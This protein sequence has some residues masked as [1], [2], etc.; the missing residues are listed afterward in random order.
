[1]SS[2]RDRNSQ[3]K[4][5]SKKGK[6]W[7]EL[8]QTIVTAGIVS[9]GIRTFAA[10]PRFIPSGSMQPTLQIDDRLIIDKVSYHFQTPKR[11]D[12]VVFSPTKI[13]QIEH[14][15]D[16][17]IKR[18]IGIPGDKIEVKQGKVY[19]NDRALVENY[20]KEIPQYQYG[21]IVVPDDRYLVLGD[22]RN[23]SY[24]S[25]Y[26]GFVPRQNFIGKA[27]VRYWPLDRIDLLD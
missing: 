23:N 19:R 1:M 18:V 25:H 17:F 9:L 2:D 14:F 20:I 24:D 27:S 16:D 4:T 12:I 21:P 13:L 8:V 3:A 26:W 10:E 22:N 5:S 11:G 7:L 15:K 6:L